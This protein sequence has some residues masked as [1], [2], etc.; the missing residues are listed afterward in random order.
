MTRKA[1]KLAWIENANART[2]CLKRRKE[3]LVKKL[4]ELTILCSINVC[5]IMFSPNEAEPMV[6]PSAEKARGLLADFNAL[7][8]VEK[9]KKQTSLESFMKEKI[10]KVHEQIMKTRKKNISY[11]IDHLMVKLHRGGG[12]HDLNL[13]E[14]YDLISFLRDNIIL[15]RKM[16]GFAQYPLLQDPPVQPQFEEFTTTTTTNDVFVRSGQEDE[17]AWKTDEAENMISIGNAIK[18]NQSHY[19]IDQWFFPSPQQPNPRIHQQIQ[20]GAVCYNNSISET[21]NMEMEP[22]GTSMITFHG[23]FGSVSQPLQN[24]NVDDNAAV[25]ISQPIQNPFNFMS[26]EELPPPNEEDNDDVTLF[27]MNKVWPHINNNHM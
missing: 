20:M 6:W 19:L 26:H 12:I 23:L 14:I 17:R 16:L 10:K 13:S 8:E 24:H 15:Y 22:V 3:G 25:A 4:K 27:D 18:E 2:I 9:T 11:A 1:I 7:S 5:M 21:A